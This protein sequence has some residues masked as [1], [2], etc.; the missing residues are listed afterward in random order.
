[1]VQLFQNLIGN[2]LKFGRDEVPPVIDVMK[3]D[4]ANGLAP[5]VRLVVAD[6]GVGVAPEFRT[7]IF[8]PFER[9]HSADE[10]PGTGLGLAVCERIVTLHDGTIAFADSPLG[11]AAVEVTLA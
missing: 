3:V 8:A 2:A 11:G 6:N 5:S 9:L 7:R 1:M 4:Q 10:V